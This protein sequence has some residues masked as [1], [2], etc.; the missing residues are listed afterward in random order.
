[1]DA[2]IMRNA[3]RR[4]SKD[5]RLIFLKITS[6]NRFLSS[7]DS[8]GNLTAN[9]SLVIQETWT[10]VRRMGACPSSRSKSRVRRLPSELVVT[11]K[12]LQ[13]VLERSFKAPS[14]LTIRAPSS[15]E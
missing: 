2:Q 6:C 14:P 15:P 13:P 7:G 1:V 9:E 8:L 11:P 3:V 4:S 5:D 12:I 10:S